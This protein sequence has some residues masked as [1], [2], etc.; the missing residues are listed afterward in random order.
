MK[1]G[2]FAMTAFMVLMFASVVMGEDATE[3]T[4]FPEWLG[5]ITLSGTLEGEFRWQETKKLC[6]IYSGGC[7]V[8]GEPFCL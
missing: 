7:T 4:L 2:I 3:R 5:R 1:K 8:K 6:L